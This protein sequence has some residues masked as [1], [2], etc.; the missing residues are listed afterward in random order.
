MRTKLLFWLSV[1]LMLSGLLLPAGAATAAT[2]ALDAFPVAQAAARITLDRSPAT[3][4]TD[5]ADLAPGNE[6]TRQIS[7]VYAGSSAA[8]VYVTSALADVVPPDASAGL[9]TCDGGKFSVTLWDGGT[10]LG[11]NLTDRL[12]RRLEPGESLILTVRHSLLLSAGNACQQRSAILSVQAYAIPDEGENPPTT[13]PAYITGRICAPKPPG[14]ELIAE[15]PGGPVTLK[16]ESN[17]RLGV[18]REYQLTIPGRGLW[19]LTLK[20]PD[21]TTV[22]QMLTVPAQPAGQPVTVRAGDFRLACTG[23]GVPVKDPPVW[24]YPVGA[25]LILA[26]LT[27]LELERRHRGHS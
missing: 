12:I 24:P 3:T 1:F 7:F 8:S 4:L 25:L 20:E 21:G 5:L 9:A 18:W 10:L 22:S 15:G 16:I 19:K 11:T 26:S 2:G 13:A 6:D 23:D 27:L 14:A 17:G